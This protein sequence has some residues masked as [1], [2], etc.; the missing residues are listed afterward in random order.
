MP[1]IWTENWPGCGIYRFKTFGGRD[2]HRSPEDVAYSVAPFPRKEEVC[3]IIIWFPKWGHFKERHRAIK[4][5]EHTLLNNKPRLG[6]LGSKQEFRNVSYT[7]PAWSVSILPDCKNLVFNTAKVGSQTSIIEM[8]P[9][10]LQPSVVSLHKYLKAINTIDYLWH[11]TSLVVDG[12]EEFLMKG[13]KPTLLI[14]S[15]GHALHAF[16]N[17]ILQAS[18]AGNGTVSPFKLKSPVSLKAGKNKIAILSMTVGLS[19]RSFYEWVGAGVTSVK[20]LRA[21]KVIYSCVLMGDLVQVQN[22]KLDFLTEKLSL[23]KIICIKRRIGQQKQLMNGKGF[24]LE[25]TLNLQVAHELEEKRKLQVVKDSDSDEFWETKLPTD[26][27]VLIN[28]FSIP[29][30]TCSSKKKLVSHLRGGLHFD[31]DN[32]THEW[33]RFANKV[34]YSCVLLGDLVQV[35]KLKLDFLTE[36]LLLNKIMWVNKIMPSSIHHLG[37]L[38]IYKLVKRSQRKG[39]LAMRGLLRLIKWKLI[40]LKR[41]DDIGMDCS[42]TH[43]ISCTKRR[44]GQ[45]KQLMNG[46]GN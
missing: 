27:E 18:G 2:P 45:Q 32:L 40:E 29:S 14:E 46:K 39:R 35:Q 21:N 30:D 43:W 34:I 11:T 33:E 44:R 5:C 4:L 13:N 8:V 3:I 24:E 37:V 1:K 41:K 12:N 6:H 15:K 16:V 36:K 25:E 17:G 38:I 28:M 22:L 42:C 20:L 10:H 23:N 19:I 7:L 26:W 9:E 31:Q